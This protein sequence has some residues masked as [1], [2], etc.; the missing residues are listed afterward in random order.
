MKAALV[1]FVLLSLF[2]V[3]SWYFIVPYLGLVLLLM[4]AV[5]AILGARELWV[6]LRPRLTARAAT[7][8]LRTN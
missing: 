4:P 5:I 3:F 6:T 8:E 7:P 1:C 2:V